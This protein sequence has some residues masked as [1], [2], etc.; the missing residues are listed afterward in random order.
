MC[1]TG[2]TGGAAY[3]NGYHAESIF[4]ASENA[5]KQEDEDCDRDGSNG[6][7]ELIVPVFVADYDDKLDGEAEE[8]EKVKLQKGNINLVDV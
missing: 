8:E 3:Y 4:P 1:E 2:D 7:V 6:E 5:G